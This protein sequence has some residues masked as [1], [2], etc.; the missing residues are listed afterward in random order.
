[1]KASDCWRERSRTAK[2]AGVVAAAAW[3]GCTGSQSALDPQG[4]QA[5]R[6]YSLWNVMFVSSI[7]IFVIVMA[8]VIVAVVRRSGELDGRRS[9]RWVVG[10]TVATVVLLI[11]LIVYDAGVTRAI[12]REPADAM[13]IRV[14]ARQFWWDFRYTGEPASRSLRT[15][16][17]VYIP[18]GRAVRFVLESPDV[19]HSFWVPNLHGKTDAIPGRVTT[20]WLRADRPGIYRGQCG[21]F[22]GLQHSKMAFELIALPPDEFERWFERELLPAAEPPDELAARGQEVFL[23]HCA[24]CHTVRGTSAMAVAGPDLTHLARRRML[25]AAWIPNQRGHLGGWILDAQRIKPGSHMPPIEVAPDDVHAL[26]HYL[27]NLR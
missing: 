20:T 21:E 17:E 25:G 26:L 19:I 12:E 2:V 11:G 16:N 10:G 23:Q 22:C 8:F 4:V 24:F 14:L 18:V 1:M 7:A 13:E 5:D 6:I 27:E 15:S 9:W 3:L